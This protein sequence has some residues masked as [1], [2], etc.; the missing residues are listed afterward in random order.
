[1]VPQ[2]SVVGAKKA[3]ILNYPYLLTNKPAFFAL[4]VALPKAIG[5]PVKS[6]KNV[7]ALPTT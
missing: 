7:A 4:S 1:M 6:R 5:C 2:I 3:V